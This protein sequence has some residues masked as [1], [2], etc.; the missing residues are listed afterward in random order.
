MLLESV[1]LSQ[2]IYNEE[3]QRKIQPYLK[4]DYF[5]NEGEKIIF[6]LIDHYTCEYNARPSV[7]ALSIMLEK[8]SL[9]EHVFEQAISALENI[10]DNTFHQEWLVKETESWARQKAVHNAIK[11]AVNIYGDEKRKDEMNTSRI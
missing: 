8:T 6:G 10:N 4:A 11:H 5:D 2:L 1:V 3:Y 7:E 9:N